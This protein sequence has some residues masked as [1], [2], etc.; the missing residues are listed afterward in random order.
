M[1]VYDRR[2]DMPVEEMASILFP[3]DL[4]EMSLLF[5][6]LKSGK[7]FKPLSYRYNQIAD[8]YTAVERLMTKGRKDINFVDFCKEYQRWPSVTRCIEQYPKQ[9][10]LHALKYVYNLYYGYVG[11]F[12]MWN[13]INFFKKYS[14]K[15]VLDPTA[16]FGNRLIAACAVGT[17]ESYI[18][19]DSNKELEEPYK[20]LCGFL[21]SRSET[22]TTMII[23]NAL[24]VD[25]TT[26][27]YDCVFTSPPYYT[28]ENYTHMKDYGKKQE[29]NENFYK[30][31]I[32]KTYRSLAPGGV[33]ALNVPSVIYT[34]C[35]VP[36]L[37][38]CKDRIPLLKK[39]RRDGKGGDYR[40]FIYV[41]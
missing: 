5:D 31:L 25:Y 22:Q 39:Q 8:H 37:G 14:P 10:L 28:L 1:A 27:D 23:N 9:T 2:I 7:D 40:E 3:S 4:Q 32:E 21:K 16:G 12:S 36:V 18:G 17:T 29:W 13:A 41:W 34:D 33:Y 19:I 30:P 24:D 38:E 15:K 20:G 11:N 26:L 6:E 35:C